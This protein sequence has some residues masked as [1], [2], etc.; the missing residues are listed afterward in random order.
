MIC[1]V[2][3]EQN[4]ENLESIPNFQFGCYEP[5]EEPVLC[6]GIKL[7][8]W[9]SLQKNGEFKLVN[10]FNKEQYSDIKEIKSKFFETS[11]KN[12][13]KYNC[14]FKMEYIINECNNEDICNKGE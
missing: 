2:Y 8:E 10:K 13:F 4:S 5:D 6:E 1:D 9:Y 11:Y 7:L 3:I 14:P 12:T